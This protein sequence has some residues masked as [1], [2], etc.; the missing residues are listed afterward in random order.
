MRKLC[1]VHNIKMLTWGF[2]EKFKSLANRCLLTTKTETIC[3]ASLRDTRRVLDK[4]FSKDN[5]DG[6]MMVLGRDQDFQTF[7]KYVNPD[8]TK[9]L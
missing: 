8:V 4:K 6:G 2:L 1:K 5:S 9:K 3:G 7:V